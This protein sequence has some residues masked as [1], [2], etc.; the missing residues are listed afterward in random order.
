[1]AHVSQ[2]KI[3]TVTE[4]K[5]MFKQYPV[6][7][8]LDVEGIPAST[9]REMRDKLRSHARIIMTKKRLMRIIFKDLS[10]ERPGIEDLNN[11]FRGMPALILTNEN[12]F[13]IASLLRKSRTPAHARAGQIAPRDIIIPKGPTAFP[14]GPIISELGA[15]GLKTGVEGG[16]VA[17][18]ED[19]VVAKEGEPIKQKVADVLTRLDIRPMTLGLTITAAHDSGIVYSQDVLEVDETFY[20]EQLRS[21]AFESFAV[22]LT[23]GVMTKET[24]APLLRKASREAFLLSLARAIPSKDNISFLIA[25]ASNHGNS[26]S[27]KISR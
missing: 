19:S 11:H 3:K 9:L 2:A 6:V 24:V 1:M 18:K 13:K 10:K 7:G 17:V 4:I 20:H 8:L 12:P 25:L 26:V 5:D 15:I 21:A 23:A 27:E 22:A 14:P 16:K